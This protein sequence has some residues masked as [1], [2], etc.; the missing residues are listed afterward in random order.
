MATI[1]V[2]DDDA[3]MRDTMFD[4][5]ALDGHEVVLADDGNTGIKRFRDSMPDLVITDIQ[6]PGTDGIELLEQLKTEFMGVPVIIMSGSTSISDFEEAVKSSASRVIRK[7][8][9][10]NTIL[11][12]VAEMTADDLVAEVNESVAASIFGETSVG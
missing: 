2:V 6:M 8:F 11:G 4:I 9:E 5:L 7:P 1:L 12:A 3:A 10:V